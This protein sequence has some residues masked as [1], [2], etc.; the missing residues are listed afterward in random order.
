MY[1]VR[2]M[3]TAGENGSHGRDIDMSE[4][5]RWVV[6]VLSGQRENMAC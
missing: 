2:V 3:E 6:G 1:R 4:M 5:G